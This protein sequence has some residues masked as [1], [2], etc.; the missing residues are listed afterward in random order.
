[1]LAKDFVPTKPF[2]G[3]KW[4]WACLQCTEGINDPVILLGILFR[5]RKL[6]DKG[7]KYSS[8]EFANELVE[9]SNDIS[10]SIGVDLARRTGKRNIIRNSGQYWRAVGLIPDDSRGVIRLTDFGR[11]VA[12][13]DISQTEF[14]AI[15]IQTFKL[16]NSH[17]QSAVE[18][19][20]WE[21]HS[22][23]IYP[24]RIILSVLIELKHR[25]QGYLTTEELTK[26]II[27]LSGCHARIEDYVNFIIWH[28]AS[29]ISLKN[30]PNCCEGANDFRI[31]REYLLFLENYGYLE[32]ETGTTRGSEQYHI[33]A[34][35][36]SEITEILATSIT[37]ASL[38]IILEQIRTSEVASEV[39][40][41]RVQN[42]RLSRP[43]QTRFR[44]DVLTACQR[45]IIT[46]VT[47]PEVLEAAHIKPFKYNGEDT[48][49]NGF[50]MRTDIH[51]L[52]DAGHLRISENGVVELST[53]A[54][55]DYG[56]SIPPRVV[57]PDFINKD[58][59]R[60][61][62]ENYNGL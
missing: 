6:E 10:D 55:M 19:M 22:L 31:A 53:R 61:R 14:S 45:C 50:A 39:E 21:S 13:H 51:T 9:L 20:N 62:W 60:W 33:N 11:R 3:F 17:I 36:E 25:G 59:L 30:W 47:M 48:V 23:I 4:K 52:F 58:F 18:C 29:E 8:Q 1:M 34:L 40:R 7:L 2:P 35:I 16:P 57:I 49:A 5:M 24:L 42:Y 38:Q 46:N 12:D 32:K 41:K 56:A 43:N 27:P 26:I 37:D 54:R 28:R 15:T 44:R